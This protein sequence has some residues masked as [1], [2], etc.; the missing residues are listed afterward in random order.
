[1]KEYNKN[2]K[3]YAWIGFCVVIAFALFVL[4][5]CY[6]AIEA[7]IWAHQYVAVNT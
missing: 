7:I 3:V 5:L 1:M 2:R 6:E 4:Y